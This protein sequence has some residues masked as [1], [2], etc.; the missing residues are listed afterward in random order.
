MVLGSLEGEVPFKTEL[1]EAFHKTKY[2]LDYSQDINAWLP[3]SHC[4]N[5]PGDVGHLSL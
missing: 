5:Y 3:K 4:F 2:K 1:A